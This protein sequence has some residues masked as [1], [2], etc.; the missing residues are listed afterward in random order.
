MKIDSANKQ[1]SNVAR[2]IRGLVLLTS[3]CAC[4][5]PRAA[6]ITWSGGPLGTNVIW[7][8]AA[9]WDTGVIPTNVDNAIF[10][11]AGTATS[12]TIQMATAG[13]TQYVNSVSLSSADTLNRTIRNNSTTAHGILAISGI[14]GILLSNNS[15]AT[16]SL[17]ES[18][19]TTSGRT[20]NP[21]LLSSGT[22]FTAV[23]GLINIWGSMSEIGGS[24]GFTKVGPGILYLRTNNTYT[25]STTNLE[26]SIKVN[27]LGTFGSGTGPIY[28][29]GGSI[30]SGADRTAA[31]EPPIANPVI[32]AAD[33]VVYNDGGTTGT[34]RT[35]PFSGPWGGSAGTLTIANLTAVTGNTF[36]MRMSGAFTFD[37]PMVVGAGFDTAGSF[38][39]LQLYNSATNGSGIQTFN[40]D[41]SGQGSIRRQGATTSAGGTSI[42]T[43]NN[44]YSG[45]T[46]ITYGTL[47]VNNTVG[48]GTGSGPVTVA[49]NGVLG[50]FGSAGSTT[51][52]YNGTISPGMSVS[53]LNVSDL[54]LGEG[55][56]YLW[57]IS[58]ATGTPGTAWDLIT[59]GG[60]A[61]TWT[62]AGSSANPIT[63]KVD[64]MGATPTG[65]S[66]STARDWV[67]IQGLASGFDSSHFALDISAFTG[68][69]SGGF[70]LSVSG[71]SLHLLYTPG[72]DL[73]INV[74]SGSQTQAAAGHPVITG[75]TNVIKIGNGEVI[76]DNPANTYSGLTKVHAGTFSL[77][78]DALNGSGALG[79]NS[80]TTLL[81]NTT[82]NSN[83]TLNISVAGVTD[84]HTVTVQSGSSG[85]KTIGTTITS[86]T[87]TFSGD[88]TL[89]SSATLAAASGGEALISGNITGS[90]GLSLAGPGTITLTAINS[91]SGTSTLSGGTLNLNNKALGTNT[92]T[93]SG[94]STLDNTSGASVT[95]N[96][97]PQNWNANFTFTGTTNLNVGPGPVTLS[98]NRNVTVNNNNLT[99]GGAIG[100]IGSLTKLGAGTLTLSAATN[101]TYT[102]GTTNSAGVIGINATATF[103]DGTGPLVL[104][105]GRILN[106][107]TRAG[108]PIANPVIITTDT[109][110]YGDSTAAAPSSR[111]L[112]FTGTFAVSGGALKIG[113]TGLSNN[114]FAVRLQGTNQTTVNWP[115]V[116]GDVAFDTP[117][118]ISQLDL[119][120]DNTT[121]T[122]TV[123][124]ALSGS[125]IVRR[126]AGTLNTGGTTIF[127]GANTHAGGTILA[128]GNIGIGINSTSSGGVVTS[129]PFGTGEF[130]IGSA[131][132]EAALGIFAAGG[133]RVVENKV[134]LNGA[135]NIVILGN[136][137]LTFSGAV[138]AGGVAKTWTVQNTGLTTLS[139]QITNSAAGSG[140]LTKAG[141]GT[142]I[143]SGDNLYAGTT[144]V[145]A[146][147]L[148]VNNTVGSGTGTNVVTVNAGGTLGGS[149]TIAGAV[150]GGGSVAPGQSAGTLTLGGGLDLSGGGTY[151]WE[152]AA[153]STNSPGTNFDVIA[154]T[155]GNLV[156]GNTSKVSINFTGTATTPDATNAFWQTT[157]S[158]KIISLSGG[159]ANPGSTQFASVVNGTYSAGSFTNSTDGSGNII[160]SFI[161]GSAVPRP[162]ISGTIAGAG[163]ASATIS[164]SSVN[165]VNYQVQYKTNLT[166]TN[167]IVLGNVTASGT[168]ASIN[169]TTGPS[170][171][172]FYRVVVP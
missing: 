58:S 141:S 164:W 79:A 85:T 110:I 45:G 88:V 149:G 142:L 81:G 82:G 155:A 166:Q 4:Q 70:S 78:V 42:F 10:G 23:N 28:M 111:F 132:N 113:N 118:A 64:S 153:N 124:T 39:V 65:W 137:D 66:S 87:A 97:C 152:L 91:Y 73:V 22:I 169:D 77:A 96:S 120:N 51:V 148:L 53:N 165:G 36:I 50:G 17:D 157:R 16:L 54:T 32:M 159:A 168:T 104:N 41:I 94:T 139:G 89:Q 103:G 172:R 2:L 102:G 21:G 128:S 59:V 8:T 6:D 135:T 29:M 167:W 49:T 90:G 115:I 31:T 34:S 116:I 67:I 145:N 150:V 5:S 80:S 55:A 112:P 38:S 107:N 161:P 127:T 162:L 151:V 99:V 125:G 114:T 15:A 109:F 9:S 158:W 40:G 61:G 72:S 130:S 60:G 11:A 105:G 119:F 140:A 46:T 122:Q 146:G 171:Q 156:L 129:G 100:G 57:Q 68:T 98:G 170:R 37:R 12:I 136:N 133:P 62:D 76:F 35:I 14:G 93:I 74:P 163:T 75:A 19:P 144:T 25:G 52:N 56:N 1:V 126:S 33:G 30:I 131:N 44:S 71:G 143:L 101:C 117:G 13:G 63:V 24:Y 108:S 47:L 18:P 106:N 84:S 121:P 138:N 92:V 3:L 48:T 86:G 95:L 69:I 134:F 123:S 20:M 147:K 83:A 27:G 160:L 7:R 26:G 154:L 43:G